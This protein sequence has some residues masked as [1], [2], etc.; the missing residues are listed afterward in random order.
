MYQAHPA[1]SRRLH[2]LLHPL[3]LGNVG[4]PETVDGLLGVADDEQLAPLGG[5]LLPR[6]GA[7]LFRDAVGYRLCQVHGYFGLDG[8]GI[9]RFVD[10]Q[11]GEASAEVVADFDVVAEE[12]PRP[13]QQ[14]VELG[15]SR[16]PAAVRR[17]RGRIHAGRLEEE[18]GPR[19]VCGFPV[20]LG[21]RGF[22]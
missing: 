4:A 18:A 8:V 9:L 1:A 3:H 21:S 13:D 15:P 19:R 16:R 12:L 11:V 5:D 6:G 2:S 7:G 20:P 17:S 22:L 10:E 14:V